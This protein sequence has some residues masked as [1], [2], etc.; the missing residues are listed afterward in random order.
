M[1]AS[2]CRSKYLPLTS[3]LKDEAFIYLDL[4]IFITCFC[5]ELILQ[6]EVGTLQKLMEG[7]VIVI[8]SIW[9]LVFNIYLLQI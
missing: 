7:I 6:S 2:L 9:H 5:C 1:K 3:L 4:F 8:A